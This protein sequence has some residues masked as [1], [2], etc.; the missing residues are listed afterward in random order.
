MQNLTI[1][2]VSDPSKM[3]PIEVRAVQNYTGE[4]IFFSDFVDLVVCNDSQSWVS[5]KCIPNSNLQNCKIE[6]IVK[7]CIVCQSNFF[8]L[9]TSSCSSTCSENNFIGPNNDCLSCLDGCSECSLDVSCTKCKNTNLK[10]PCEEKCKIK[11]K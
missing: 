1:Y 5:N 6:S 4:I 3:I 9:N 11:F 8:L 7:Q 2:E 10:P